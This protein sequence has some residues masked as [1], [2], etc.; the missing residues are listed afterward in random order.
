MNFNNSRLVDHK[1]M[2][3]GTFIPYMYC[4]VIIVKYLT[5]FFKLEWNLGIKFTLRFFF[6]SVYLHERLFCQIDSFP[7][8]KAF[9][10]FSNVSQICSPCEQIL[11]SWNG[12]VFR[13]GLVCSKA[14]RKLENLSPLSEMAE[15][16]SSVSKK[17]REKSKECH[18]HKPQPIPDTRRKRKQTKPNKRKSKK[19]TKNIKI[20]SL[21]PEVIAMLKGL[22]NTITK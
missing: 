9:F 11:S 2:E 16:L 21:F 8:W 17:V 22:K 7:F 4:F 14:I 6:L 18:N 5:N 3:F 13:G 12:A 20:S 1:P 15:N 19:H 10:F